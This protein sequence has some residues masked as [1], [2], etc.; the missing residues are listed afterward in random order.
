MPLRTTEAESE[1]KK[2]RK[3]RGNERGRA[4]FQSEQTQKTEGELR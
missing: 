2:Q 1:H 4:A 3:H